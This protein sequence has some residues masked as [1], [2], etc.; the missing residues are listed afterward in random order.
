VADLKKKLG[1][2]ER[3]SGPNLHTQMKTKKGPLY[4]EVVRSKKAWKK[5][6]GMKYKNIPTYLKLRGHTPYMTRIANAVKSRLKQPR[7]LA[8]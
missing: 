1:L 3:F 7:R 6:G 2:R 8:K 4:D 5:V